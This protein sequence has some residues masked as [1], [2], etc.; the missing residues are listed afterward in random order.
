M[1]IPSRY[2]ILDI[3][4]TALVSVNQPIFFGWCNMKHSCLETG[5]VVGNHAKVE[6]G[7]V[8]YPGQCL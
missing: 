6:L 2:A 5:L 3:S 4:K 8:T 7:G 1:F